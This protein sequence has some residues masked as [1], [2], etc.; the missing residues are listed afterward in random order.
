MK[1]ISREKGW[2]V[3][4]GGKFKVIV[5]TVKEA[6]VVVVV[7]LIDGDPSLDHTYFSALKES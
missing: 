5:Q 7:C 6:S 3:F 2:F 1:E 4:V